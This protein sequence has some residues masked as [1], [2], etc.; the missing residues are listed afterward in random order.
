MN[1]EE[2]IWKSVP[3]YEGY[4]EIS[5]TGKTKSLSRTILRN[6]KWPVV[7]KEKI[8]TPVLGTDGYLSVVLCKN[9]IMKRRT[10]HQLVAIAFLNHK[11]CGF[12]LVVNHKD[13]NKLNNHVDNLEIVTH[14]ENSNLKHKPSSSKYVGVYWHKQS[15]KWSARIHIKGKRKHLGEY[16]NEEDAAAAYELEFKKCVQAVHNSL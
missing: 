14:R 3:S 10:I 5:N 2:E 16:S 9:G 15:Q 13:L 8:M 1:T 7:W 6:G 11:I 12:K 4:Y